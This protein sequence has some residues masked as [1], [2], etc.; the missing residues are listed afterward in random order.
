[1]GPKLLIGGVLALVAIGIAGVVVYRSETEAIEKRG[2]ANEEFDPSATPESSG[3]VNAREPWPTFGYDAQRNKVS[4]YD[5]RPPFRRTW[6]IDAH[7]TIEFPPSAA[8]GN[9]YLAQQKGLFFALDGRT[10]R[11]VFKRKDFKRCAASSPTVR[12]GVVYQSYMHWAPCP[13]GA[14]NPTGFVTAMS[15]KTGREKWRFRRGPFES[16]PLVRKGVVYVGNWDHNVYAISART[17]RKIW[18]FKTDA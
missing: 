12:K 7:D 9:L 13:Q 17:G 18:S 15:A 11:K 2:S 5:H 4:P 6:R 14:P 1:M 3:R 16:S 10:G 8:Y